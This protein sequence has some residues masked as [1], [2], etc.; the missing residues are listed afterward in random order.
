MPPKKLMI[1][2]GVMRITVDSGIDI[3]PNNTIISTLVSGLYEFHSNVALSDYDCTYNASTK[4]GNY[5]FAAS[6]GRIWNQVIDFS[7]SLSDPKH[8]F[9]VP[10][11]WKISEFS[12]HRT[13]R[14]AY[15]S[16]VAYYDLKKLKAEFY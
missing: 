4:I 10:S 15:V 14:D 13:I 16:L 1:Q 3:S 5:S 12:L 11:F 6:D 7:E 2:N 8:N 9:N